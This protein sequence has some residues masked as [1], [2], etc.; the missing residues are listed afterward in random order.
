MIDS[1]ET[2]TKR[3]NLQ[4]MVDQ[5]V[6]IAG[7]DTAQLTAHDRNVAALSGIPLAQLAVQR[8]CDRSIEAAWAALTPDEA[9]ALRMLDGTRA[10]PRTIVAAKKSAERELVA[11][12]YADRAALSKRF[13][14]DVVAMSIAAK[15]ENL[16]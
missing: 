10:D 1:N 8:A 12:S 16:L 11:L 15:N 5:V 14:G 9:A 2:Q 3:I 7:A 6:D 13:G 4:L